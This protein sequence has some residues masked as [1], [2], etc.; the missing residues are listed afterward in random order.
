MCEPIRHR[1]RRESGVHPLKLAPEM[2]LY[3]VGRARLDP[4][5]GL[6]QRRLSD[7][8]AA[9][10]APDRAGVLIH[11]NGRPRSASRIDRSKYTDGVRFL[12]MLR[13]NGC[14]V[15]RQHRGRWSSADEERAR[16]LTERLTTLSAGQPTASANVRIGKLAGRRRRCQGSVATF[17]RVSQL[18]GTD[19]LDPQRCFISTL[20]VCQDRPTPSSSSC[21]LCQREKR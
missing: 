7:L 11:P 18:T 19:R 1:C 16:S 2:M 8:N 14:V 21:T 15:S 6:F 20:P 4:R 5:G 17:R 12:L 9:G 13:S 10:T 3:R